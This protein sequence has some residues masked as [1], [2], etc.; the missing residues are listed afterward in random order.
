MY[1]TILNVRKT[2]HFTHGVVC[3]GLDDIQK[4]PWLFL[5]LFNF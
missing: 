3:I 5:K 2:L 1:A 4:N